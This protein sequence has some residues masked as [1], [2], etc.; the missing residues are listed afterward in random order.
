MLTHE[1]YILVMEEKRSKNWSFGWDSS[2]MLSFNF[3]DFTMIWIIDFLKL[4]LYVKSCTIEVL[5]LLKYIVH[6]VTSIVKIFIVLGL[7][8][9]SNFAF[10]HKDKFKWKLK[11]ISHYR[12][13]V[14]ECKA[15]QNITSLGW[16]IWRFPWVSD[17]VNWV[18]FL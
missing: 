3:I 18:P 15:N 17:N 13:V 2:R 4:L 10:F 6:W 16:K 7:L 12:D 8:K 5:T 1:D 11:I 14:C 9:L